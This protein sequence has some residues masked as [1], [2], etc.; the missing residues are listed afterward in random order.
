MTNES[1][2]VPKIADRAGP[3][4]A[5]IA[6]A[7]A[8]D[9][10]SGALKPGDRLP[11]HR[12]LA[13]WL[14]V[15]VGTVT[16]AYAE[17][18]RRGLISGEVGR[19]S[20]VKRPDLGAP[21]I[22]EDA[23][24]GVIDFS[25]NLPATCDGARRLADTLGQLARECLNPLLEYQPDGGLPHHRAAGARWLAKAGVAARPENIV[26]TDG[27][28]HAMAVVFLAIAGPGDVV[29]TEALTFHGMKELAAHLRLKLHGLPMD[30]E[31]I[32]PEAFEQACR[33]L[34][35]RALYCM[36]NLQNPTAAVMGVA[37]R[38]AIVEIARRHGV[39]LVED[40]VYG[41]LLGDQ[42]PPPLAALAP[43]ITYHLTSLS[44]S[45]APGLRVGYVAT[46]A[47][48]GPRVGAAVRVTCRMATPLM[49]EIAARWIQDGQAEHF[50]EFQRREV[51]AR[52]AIAGQALAGVETR[53]HPKSFHLWIPLP[54]P[55]RAEDFV[56]ALKDQGVLVLP[57]ET[58]AVART[59]NPHAVRV[60]LGAPRTRDQVAKGLG[61]LAETLRAPAAPLR[62]V[63]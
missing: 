17:A 6:E 45:V 61:L 55:W 39:I 34:K 2:W 41:F 14:Q 53:T 20:F 18:Q 24:D 48:Q 31:G 63:V 27:A 29:L 5:A 54:E 22:P 43:E 42:A 58:F 28:Q 59:E 40:D 62:A 37:R 8:D 15:S 9:V 38:E 57:A 26:V 3:R 60:C 50:A 33:T 21:P 4:H 7:I 1:R 12:D 51:A 16:R 19:G 13:E 10:A 49:A 30:Q 56:R 47:G 46:P 36:P 44:K 23:G 52:R 25:L 32:I 35:P 11:T